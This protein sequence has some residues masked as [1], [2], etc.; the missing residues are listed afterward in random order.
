[1]DI[2]P[3]SP[4]LNGDQPMVYD[5]F[6]KT[7]NCGRSLIVATSQGIFK[8]T[9]NNT[10]DWTPIGMQSAVATFSAARSGRKLYAGTGR[11]IMVTTLND[12]GVVPDFAAD[13]T[14]ICPGDIIQFNDRSQFDPIEWRWEFEGGRPAVA[15]ERNPSIQ[16]LNSGPYSVKLVVR[17]NCGMD[18]VIRQMIT[19]NPLQRAAIQVQRDDY[20]STDTI[21]VTDAT[22]GTGGIRNWSVTGATYSQRTANTIAI[23]PT[24]EG[25]I[26]LDLTVNNVCGSSTVAKDIFIFNSPV[27]KTITNMND[28]LSVENTVGLRYQWYLGVN[29]ITGATSYSH[30]PTVNGSYYVTISN[31]GGCIVRSDTVLFVKNT[32]T[33]EGDDPLSQLRIYPHPASTH[34]TLEIP[35][36]E[37]ATL[38]TVRIVS[39]LGE[40]IRTEFLTLQYGKTTLSLSGLAPGTYIVHVEGGNRKKSARLIKE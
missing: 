32:L 30:S 24:G 34:V 18:S 39:L 11:G 22:P 27:R 4:V 15:N 40:L 6:F 25:K 1:I 21:I 16:Y 36:F 13:K 35:G 38:F 9:V 14:T 31:Q 12:I 10:S 8:R 7:D 3:P 2:T 17:N 23:I 33:V 5:A 28:I 26:S 20:C 37:N 29:A 19:V